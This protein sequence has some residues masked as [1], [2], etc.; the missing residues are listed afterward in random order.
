MDLSG[1]QS[2]LLHTAAGSPSFQTEK[3][4]PL[5]KQGNPKEKAF[6]LLLKALFHIRK[7]TAAILVLFFRSYIFSP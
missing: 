7:D 2:K 4:A 3:K 5:S 6:R 1:V